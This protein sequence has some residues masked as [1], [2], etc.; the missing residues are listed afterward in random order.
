MLYG[1]DGY[2]HKIDVL[3]VKPNVFKDSHVDSGNSEDCCVYWDKYLKNKGINMK[4]RLSCR[5]ECLEKKEVRLL[6]DASMGRNVVEVISH[7]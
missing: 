2:K 7:G 5:L 3:D 1:K 4:M 6:D